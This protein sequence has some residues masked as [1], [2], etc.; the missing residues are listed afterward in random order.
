MKVDRQRIYDAVRAI[1]EEA[2]AV[3]MSVLASELGV[4]KKV[5]RN[6]LVEGRIFQEV[7]CNVEDIELVSILVNDYI[8]YIESGRKSGSFPPFNVIAKWAAEKGITTDNRVVWAICQSIYKEGIAPRPLIDVKG[9]FW[10]QIDQ[11]WDNWSSK[12]FEAI[13]EEIDNEFD[14]NFK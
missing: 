13:T 9:G 2:K 5:G 14:N 10:E 6:T 8:K 4:N 1:A 3:M 12:I 11:E 7:G